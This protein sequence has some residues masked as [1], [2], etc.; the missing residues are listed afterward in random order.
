LHDIDLL[1]TPVSKSTYRVVFFAAGLNQNVK[2]KKED[3]G[4]E[5]ME[6]GENFP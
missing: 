3:I 2:G 1:G 6:P 5:I 4:A